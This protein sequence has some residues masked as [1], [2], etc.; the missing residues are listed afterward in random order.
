LE[1]QQ[2][3]RD[4]NREVLRRLKDRIKGTEDQRTNRPGH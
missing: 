2:A 3:E 1:L 4:F